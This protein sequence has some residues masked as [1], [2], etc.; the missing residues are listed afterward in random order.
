MEEGM[1]GWVMGGGGGQ[2][3]E[4]CVGVLEKVGGEGGGSGVSCVVCRRV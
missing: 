3:E 4:L 1:G 2:K